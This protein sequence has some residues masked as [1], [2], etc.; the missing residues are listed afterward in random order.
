MLILDRKRPDGLIHE[1]YNCGIFLTRLFEIDPL[2]LKAKNNFLPLVYLVHS[3]GNNIFV[4]AV[5]AY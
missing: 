3:F 2:G 4:P 5:N 1:M